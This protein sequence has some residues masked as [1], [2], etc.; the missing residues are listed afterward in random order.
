MELP[1]AWPRPRKAKWS[2]LRFFL[3]G[4]RFRHKPAKRRFLAFIYR[5]GGTPQ[6]PPL[7]I[8]QQQHHVLLRRN[9]QRLQKLCLVDVQ[10]NRIPPRL[11][12]YQAAAQGRV[13]PPSIQSIFT[14]RNKQPPRLHRGSGNCRKPPVDL[15]LL[16]ALKG[17]NEQIQRCGKIRRQRYLCPIQRV[18]RDRGQNRGLRSLGSLRSCHR[19]RQSEEGEN[20]GSKQSHFVYQILPQPI[21]LGPPFDATR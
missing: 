16:V 9:L 3:M 10:R 20:Q 19:A 13:Q 4:R 21:P 14:R 17:K 5:S 6:H 1:P 18:R 12:C 7:L 15:R 11:G 8:R 2:D